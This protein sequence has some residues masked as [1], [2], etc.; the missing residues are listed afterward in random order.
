M[1]RRKILYVVAAVL[2]LLLG[3]VLLKQVFPEDRRQFTGASLDKMD[4]LEISFEN[5]AQGLSLGGLLFVP[6][7]EGPFPAAV[8]I[9]GSGTSRRDNGWYLTLTKFLQENGVVV[10]LPD[11]RGSEKSG[12]DW[13]TSSF[14]DLATDTIAA[15]DFLGE[16][17]H[18]GVTAVGVVGMSQGG[19]I[20]PIVATQSSEVEF[21]VSMV[22]AAVTTHEQ[23]AYE[24]NHNLRQIGFLPGISQL[25]SAMSTTYIKHIGQR[26]FWSAVGDFDPLP[27]WEKV[28]V[29]A[30]ALLGSDDTNVPSRESAARLYALKKSNIRVSIYEGSGHPLED[31]PEYGNSIIRYDALEDISE[32][33]DA[34]SLNH[35]TR[36]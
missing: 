32:F 22:G 30:F 21:V 18:V 11:K 14:E 10:L 12:G 28:D 13:R 25:I 9:H 8:V 34:A 29:N 36:E 6:E 20:A 1:N 3:P 19:W 16:Q 31:P 33:I 2:L 5:A 24:E 17:D 7:G 23:L 15:V 4:F 26:S 27:Y 35:V